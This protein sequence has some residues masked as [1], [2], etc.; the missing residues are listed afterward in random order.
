M[1][2]VYCLVI[3][4]KP[5]KSGRNHVKINGTLLF[6]LCVK[7]GRPDLTCTWYNFNPSQT[8]QESA[9]KATRSYN[10]EHIATLPKYRILA[11]KRLEML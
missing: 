2:Q 5:E 10:E 6:V 4:N 9:E 11:L 3:K 1:E 7:L 8:L